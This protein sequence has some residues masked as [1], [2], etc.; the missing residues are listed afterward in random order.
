MQFT[1]KKKEQVLKFLPKWFHPE[2]AIVSYTASGPEF[3]LIIN[4]WTLLHYAA[5]NGWEDVCKVLV[6]KY[7]GDPRFQ[8]RKNKELL[9]W[10]Y[11]SRVTEHISVNNKRQY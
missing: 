11:Q 8:L 10:V 5:W 3:R 4:N 9:G 1:L 7:N 6:E 2:T